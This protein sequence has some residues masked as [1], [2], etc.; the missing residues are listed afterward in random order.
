MKKII[1]LLNLVMVL[2][3][4]LLSFAESYYP[5]TVETINPSSGVRVCFYVDGCNNMRVNNA[6]VKAIN[7]LETVLKSNDNNLMQGLKQSGCSGVFI[8]SKIAYLLTPS[9]FRPVDLTKKAE[10]ADYKS[11]DNSSLDEWFKKI[12]TNERNQ[13]ANN[14]ICI[15]SN[16]KVFQTT[17]GVVRRN[18]KTSFYCFYA[19]DK[20]SANEGIIWDD[21]WDEARWAEFI[22]AS[23][24]V[25]KVAQEIAADY[26]NLS[27]EEQNYAVKLQACPNQYSIDL[28]GLLALRSRPMWST[29]IDVN[30]RTYS[31]SNEDA[32]SFPPVLGENRIVISLIS[33]TGGGR[34]FAWGGKNFTYVK[35]SDQDQ[36][37]LKTTLA[38]AEEIVK[39]N[40]I[41]F[42]F[43]KDYDILKKSSG[44][45]SGIMRDDVKSEIIAARGRLDSANKENQ[46]LLE[47]YTKFSRRYDDIMARVKGLDPST[48]KEFIKELE[49]IKK[50]E[51]NNKNFNQNTI[52]VLEKK[53][54]TLEGRVQVVETS[55]EK[56]KIKTKVMAA[57]EEK[58]AANSNAKNLKELEDLLAEAKG[59]D[60]KNARE[61]DKLNKI[62]S[63]L[64]NW[65][66]ITESEFDKKKNEL[67]ADI[68]SK[69]EANGQ[70][71]NKKDLEAFLKDAQA[72]N[73][74]NPGDG[75]KLD[76]LI[77]SVKAWKPV[78][79]SEFEKERSKVISDIQQK[80]ADNP[81]AANLKDLENLL[82]ETK[83]LDEKNADAA[84]RLQ[85]IAQT[86]TA[87]QPKEEE[88]SVDPLAE[89]RQKVL[90]VLA[91]K[92]LNFP[93]KYYVNTSEL[94]DFEEEINTADSIERLQ[95]IKEKIDS[96][97][98]EPGDPGWPFLQLLLFL[99]VI[100]AAGAGVYFFFFAP[101][102]VATINV[103]VKD[104]EMDKPLKT[105]VETGLLDIGLD[106]RAKV[107]K[108]G[109]DYLLELRTTAGD[110]YLKSKGATV[111]KMIKIT[112]D[113][114]TQ[115]GEGAYQ[116]FKSES[117]MVDDG[118][119]TWKQNEE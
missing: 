40:L 92:K 44:K 1:K 14:V 90:E 83:A 8:D 87:W 10:K 60:V 47:N 115:I 42:A 6:Y 109:E 35:L 74:K 55:I 50:E 11:E 4:P 25:N 99:V 28:K 51:G 62:L 84:E 7:A 45:W 41:K 27:N 107:V 23:F 70:A 64:E 20:D 15:I 105:N 82:E 78:Y 38:K 68:K 112:S 100:A 103:K 118:T 116:I 52:E 61:F 30:G 65:K 19:P 37:S 89:E 73:E 67:V 102:V 3:A 81:Q 16:N 72:L 63:Q 48:A 33:P 96:W 18:G 66:P 2:T 71:Q 75:N 86:V 110:M 79:E 26:F 29:S 101:K 117:S 22:N 113:V 49:E 36:S 119:L 85:G 57:I 24:Y 91:D 39:N 46:T 13:N 95:D 108:S 12:C 80:I 98:G 17:H 58:I 56:L 32:V 114:A 97:E 76:N 69:I 43:S 104:K 111:K 31:Q 9:A 59:V 93:A 21:G 34:T 77:N 5:P 106:M 53:L 94:D 88:P 54:T